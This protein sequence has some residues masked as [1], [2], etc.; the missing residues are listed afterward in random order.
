MPHDYIRAQ[1]AAQEQAA[2]PPRRDAR[3]KYAR[4]SS[5]GSE[6]QALS[7]PSQLQE[8]DRAFPDL[9]CLD[10]PIIETKSAFHPGRKEFSAL[11]E[12]VEKGEV[13]EIVAWHP[14]R[15]AR[16]ATDAATIIR[17]IDEGKLDLKFVTYAFEKTPEGILLL[18]HILSQ[19]QYESER[20]RRDVRRGTNKKVEQGW[21][22]GPVPL[23]YA[24]DG[25]STKKGHRTILIDEPRLTIIER[26]MTHALTGNYTMADLVRLATEWGLTTR[27]TEVRDSRLIGYGGIRGM[28]RNVF[29]AGY[30]LWDGELIEGKHKAVITLEQYQRLQEIFRH[31]ELGQARREGKQS[32]ARFSGIITC[33]RCGRAVTGYEKRKHYI[34]TNREATYVYYSC[35]RNSRR[36]CSEAHISEQKLVSALIERLSQYRI[37]AE[38]HDTI[39][40]MLI[41]D[42]QAT[43]S[44]RKIEFEGQQKEL[45]SL[46][47]R[48]KNLTD[49]RASGEIDKEDYAHY[50]TDYKRRI[51]MIKRRLV[52][53]GETDWEKLVGTLK[54][55]H[56]T[57]GIAN[58]FRMADPATQRRMFIELA[59]SV[60][61]E[62][63][64]AY[65]KAKKWL[66]PLSVPFTLPE[67]QYELVR[68]SVF[69]SIKRKAEAF[70]SAF[71]LWCTRVKTVTNLVGEEIDCGR[72]V[73]VTVELPPDLQAR[74]DRL[75]RANL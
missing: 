7:I 34:G 42:Y 72:T 15:L 16:N 28:L 52:Q 9:V 41:T 37:V 47:D 36:A 19:G 12:R 49:M 30:F 39:V 58:T 53:P 1:V 40:N 51:D 20:L 45:D 13:T 10:D 60:I 4:K 22:P 8:M 46:L 27:K 70:A 25:L 38:V 33:G 69:D 71:S 6:R 29:Y 43:R 55:I 5:D 57:A 64:K 26:I 31:K 44:V 65:I 75:K 54:A 56:F 67:A 74:L 62:D 24:T 68:T 23:G 66:V 32:R 59:D 2:I 11:I 21:F 48:D 35:S 73:H 50:H 63:G 18:Q 14:N 17:L 61:L 3:I